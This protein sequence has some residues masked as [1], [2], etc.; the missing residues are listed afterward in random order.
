MSPRHRPL[1]EVAPQC[2][3]QAPSFSPQFV[4]EQGLRSPGYRPPALGVGNAEGI[5]E[6]AHMADGLVHG[7]G[8]VLLVHA[9]KVAGAEQR[10]VTDG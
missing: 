3:V 10:T 9:G 7:Q 1:H 2:R 8:G 4:A 6:G 5:V